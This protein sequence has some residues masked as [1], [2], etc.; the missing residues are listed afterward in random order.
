M[1]LR[2]RPALKS[3]VF[4]SFFASSNRKMA[5]AAVGGAGEVADKYTCCEDGKSDCPCFTAEKTRPPA[6]PLALAPM[7]VNMTCKMLMQRSDAC[8]AYKCCWP[9]GPGSRGSLLGSVRLRL[10]SICAATLSLLDSFEI[11]RVVC[12]EAKTRP[13]NSTLSALYFCSELCA[14][15]H[16]T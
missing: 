2:L 13:A 3:R 12:S 7:K 16:R 10:K 5:A 8:A 11:L 9:S 1:L 6:V 14:G 15:H 4:S